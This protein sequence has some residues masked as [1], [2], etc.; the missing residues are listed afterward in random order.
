MLA[1][2]NARIAQIAQDR[3]ASV[4][5]SLRASPYTEQNF[6]TKF[7]STMQASHRLSKERVDLI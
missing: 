5:R 1:P 2:T 4:K 3:M 7:E 6:T